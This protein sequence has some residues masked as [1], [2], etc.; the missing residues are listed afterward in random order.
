MQWTGWGTPGGFPTQLLA[1][2]EDPTG[3][4]YGSAIALVF[5]LMLVLFATGVL[6]RDLGQVTPM[7][8]FLSGIVIA[9]ATAAV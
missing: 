8:L 7:A 9:L 5:V 1:M 2:V 4:A 3:G 6:R